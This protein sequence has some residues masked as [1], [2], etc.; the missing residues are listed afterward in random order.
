MTIRS[1]MILLVYTV[2]MAIAV[3]LLLPETVAWFI[4]VLGFIGLVQLY[5]YLTKQSS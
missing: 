3:W 2:G 4:A 1:L 5:A